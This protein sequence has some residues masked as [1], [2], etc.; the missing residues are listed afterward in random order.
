MAMPLAVVLRY[1]DNLI[2]EYAADT[3]IEHNKV[4]DE[5]G[6]AF[7]GK[8]GRFIGNTCIKLC[9]D[10]KRQTHLILVKKGKQGYVF[11]SAPIKSA[12]ATRP[13]SMLIPAYYRNSKRITSWICIG[14]KLT[15]LDADEANTW[16]IKS[17]RMPLEDSLRMS[18]A[19]YFIAEKKKPITIKSTY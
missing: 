9:N 16:V 15:L 17:S 12:Q 5:H 14:D 6:K 13:D 1:A 3:I 10:D 18:M 8:L 4:V 19:A 2:G 7:V 11:H